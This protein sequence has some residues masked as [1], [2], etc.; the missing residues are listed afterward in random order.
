MRIALISTAQRSGCPPIGLVYLASHIH[1]NTE[2]RADIVDANYQDTYRF[3]Y[4]PY[5]IIGISAMTVSYA[6][7]TGLARHIR[8][9]YKPKP[10]VI[11]GVHISTCI[12]S[13]VLNTFDSMVIGEGEESFLRL[14]QDYPNIKPR[15]ES[16]PISDLD[17]LTPPDWRLLNKHYFQGQLNTTFAER[18]VEGW[19]LT[20][21]GCP[22]KCR[23][24]STTL[25]WSKVRLHS[26]YYVKCMVETWQKLGATH[27]QI[28]DDLFTMNK[29]RLKQLAP[30]LK[31][32]GIRFNCQPRINKIDR[33]TCE[34]LRDS[35]VSLCIFGFES[36]N[37]ERLRFLKNDRGLSV[38]M[39][40]RAIKLCKDNK[41]DVQGSVIFG[42][43]KERIGEMLDTLKFMLWG[44]FN[45]IQRLW[46][47][48]AT[49]FPATEFWQYAPANLSWDYYSHHNIKKPLLLD[50]SVKLWQFRIIMW[51]AHR[52]EGLYKVKKLWKILKSL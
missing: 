40:K 4:H 29:D 17:D 51:L 9:M 20:S 50:K 44:L 48:V 46:A 52:I 2:H 37:S 47:F 19:L 15:Y 12:E 23:F 22:Y 21:R 41:L 49:P 26:P 11:G 42:S 10:I 27:I 35:G 6:K 39:S 28:W 13:Q 14:L 8:N 45:G 16:A 7:A 3:D 5:D 31:E 33:E 38:T 24:C 32:S 36:G 43:P 1:K 25:H 30:I 18:G 34:I